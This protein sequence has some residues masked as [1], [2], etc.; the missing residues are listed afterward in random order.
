MNLLAIALFGAAGGVLRLLVE[1]ELPRGGFPWPT[2]IINLAGS[3]LLGYVHVAANRKGWPGWLEYGI[4]T[5]LIGSFTTFSTFSMDVWT[6]LH[7]SLMLAA[8][9]L[10]ASIVGG[11]G[12]AWMGGAV[13]TWIYAP[14]RAAKAADVEEV[15]P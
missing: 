12:C 8:V 5:G 6:L 4:G 13:A 1:S 11:V 15:Y 3:L 14:G 9:Y 2:L 7:T 10:V